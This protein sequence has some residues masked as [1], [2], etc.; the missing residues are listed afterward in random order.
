MP[1]RRS[2][3][4]VAA[5]LVLATVLAPSGT[6]TADVPVL[7]G[8]YQVSS[9]IDGECLHA[10]P[11]TATDLVTTRG[12]DPLPTF[13]YFLRDGADD[14]YLISPLAGIDQCLTRVADH[15]V[16]LEPCA[17]TAAAY[18]RIAEDGAAVVI[19]DYQGRD[20]LVSTEGDDGSG[21]AADRVTT[22]RHG[23]AEERWYLSMSVGS[24]LP[25]P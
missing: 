12:C 20:V 24:D 5:A 22:S 21:L 14:L 17:A 10:D 18:W 16:D 19:A 7:D 1:Y 9:S 23:H 8:P 15:E 4:R 13:W 3:R 25:A 2:G 6:A 11:F